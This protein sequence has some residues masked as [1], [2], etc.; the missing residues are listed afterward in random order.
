MYLD[1]IIPI[2]EKL[3]DSPNNKPVLLHIKTVKGYG[4]PPAEN[5]SDRMHG[6]GKFNLGTGAQFKGKPG[7]PSIYRV[8]D[9]FNLLDEAAVDAYLRSNQR[10][11]SSWTLW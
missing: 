3:R 6:V 2:L 4:Y 5:A 1:P 8:F 9:T 7:E 11:K 10:R